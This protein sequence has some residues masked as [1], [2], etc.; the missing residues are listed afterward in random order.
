[1]SAE[2]K[3]Q[4]LFAD[5]AVHAITPGTLKQ[6]FLELAE[7]FDEASGA[8]SSDTAPV[9]NR[10]PSAAPISS[11]SSHNYVFIGDMAEQLKSNT[12]KFFSFADPSV[13][14]KLYVEIHKEE[15]TDSITCHATPNNSG[16]S[17]QVIFSTP[18]FSY[19]Y[20]RLAYEIVDADNDYCVVKAHLWYGSNP[21]T[22]SHTSNMRCI[23]K[24]DINGYNLYS[25]KLNQIFAN[26]V[27]CYVYGI[28]K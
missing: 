28:K 20:L 15:Q 9:P 26:T 5:Y 2:N 12:E 4:A 21:T 24:A 18:N 10:A 11:E 25:S 6:L 3:V 13:Y 1:M 7:V 14:R 8:T 16:D 22:V 23:Q 17:D 19:E 27:H